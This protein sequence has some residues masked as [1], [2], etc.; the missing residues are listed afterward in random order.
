MHI[1]SQNMFWPFVWAITSIACTVSPTSAQQSTA[2]APASVQSVGKQ[3]VSAVLK[4]NVLNPTGLVQKTGKLLPA[5]GSW[6][7]GKEAPASC[8][9]ITEHCVRVLYRVPDADVLCEWDVQLTA[10]GSDGTILEQN[11]DATRYFLRK[12]PPEQAEAMVLETK[13]PEYPQLALAQHMQG[14]VAILVTFSS[15]GKAEKVYV[16]SGS[17]LL[18]DAAVDAVKGWIMKPV[19]AGKR[20]IPFQTILTINFQR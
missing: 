7:I 4:Q 20:A 5:N 1:R 15:E 8:P 13:R 16:L 17:P 9:Q 18:K 6:A 3:A 12:I 11:D 2:A 14:A 10:D 19:M